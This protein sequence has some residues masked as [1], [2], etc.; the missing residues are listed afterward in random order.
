MRGMRYNRG[1][2]EVMGSLPV[3]IL[4]P[5]QVLGNVIWDSFEQQVSLKASKVP[6]HLNYSLVL[7]LSHRQ[8][9]VRECRTNNYHHKHFLVGGVHLTL[10]RAWRSFRTNNNPQWNRLVSTVS[11]LVSYASGITKRAGPMQFFKSW[12]LRF[13]LC[14]FFSENQALTQCLTISECPGM[15]DKGWKCE[16]LWKTTFALSMYQSPHQLHWAVPSLWQEM[17]HVN[18]TSESSFWLLLSLVF[19]PSSIFFFSPS[20][21]GIFQSCV[22]DTC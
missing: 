13:E 19:L 5:H 7:F 1:T 20:S 14:I 10:C 12:N 22:I 15:T 21:G 17:N 4:K 16:L 2:R 6:S 8:S 3:E 18:P 9:S 11:N